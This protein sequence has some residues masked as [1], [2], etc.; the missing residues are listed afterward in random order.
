MESACKCISRFGLNLD[1]F[2]IDCSCPLRANHQATECFRKT[3]NEIYDIT[4]YPKVKMNV[5][6]QKRM[7]ILEC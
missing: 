5:L 1:P 7:N 2:L 3:C 4:S 6:L